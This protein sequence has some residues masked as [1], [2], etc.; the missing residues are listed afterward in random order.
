[1]GTSSSTTFKSEFNNT[2]DVLTRG[3]MNCQNTTQSMQIVNVDGSGNVLKNVRQVAKFDFNVNCM[4]NTENLS[5]LQNEIANSIVQSSAAVSPGLIGAANN[6]NSDVN[7]F[8]KQDIEN[9]ITTETV[10]NMLTSINST[11]Y[12]RIQGDKNIVNN[13]SQE[14]TMDI[15]TK[16]AQSLLM[17]LDSYNKSDSKGDQKSEAT[18]TNFI[19]EI[20]DSIS[21]VLGSIFGGMAAAWLIVILVFVAIFYGI[22]KLFSKGAS[23]IKN[24]VSSKGDQKDVYTQQM[25]P[26]MQ[27]SAP[28]RPPMQMSAPMRPPMQMSAPMRPSQYIM[29]K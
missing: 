9:N 7:T 23:S 22:Y 20:I 24:A 28:M 6:T 2:L 14:I 5:K 13:I 29:A 25:R 21:S 11:Q 19:S 8:I 18:T 17:N 26:P 3:I 1:M 12:V 10:S 27:M 4:N 15:V 16:A